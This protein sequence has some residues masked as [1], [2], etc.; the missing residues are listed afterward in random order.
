[1]TEIELKLK[2][3]VKEQCAIFKNDAKKKYSMEARG[4]NGPAPVSTELSVR[5]KCGTA[6][7][8]RNADLA[9]SP[10]M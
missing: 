7:G 10:V 8:L 5:L 2:L 4:N 9:C 6:E 3:K 1:M